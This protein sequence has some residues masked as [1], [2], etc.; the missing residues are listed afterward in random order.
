MRNKEEN[1]YTHAVISLVKKFARGKDVSAKEMGT[2]II[3]FTFCVSTV[4]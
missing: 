1:H 3:L 2:N 4:F